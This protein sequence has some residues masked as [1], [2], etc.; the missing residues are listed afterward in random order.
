MTTTAPVY[1]RKDQ[2]EQIQSGLMEG[3]Q[4]SPSMTRSAPAP[5]S[6]A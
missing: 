6:S 2:F 5:A 4:I 1:D 3:E